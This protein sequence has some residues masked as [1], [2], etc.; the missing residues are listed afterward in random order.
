MFVW[1]QSQGRGQTGDGLTLSSEHFEKALWPRTDLCADVP[2]DP[3]FLIS[4]M[5]WKQSG[6]IERRH[7]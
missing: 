3:A 1:K 6:K 2:E 5:K 4:L 7:R